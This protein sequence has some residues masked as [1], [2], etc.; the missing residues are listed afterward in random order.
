[1]RILILGGTR[2]LG[3]AIT[4]AAL[5]RGD[6]VTL[7]NRGKSSPGLYPGLE[8]VIG[9][10]AADLSA[11]DGREWDAVIDVACYDPVVA[12]LSA[13]AFADRAG[14]YVFVSTVSV[15]ASQD[16]TQA[17]LEDAPV[18][19]LREGMQFPESYGPDKA[20]CEQVVHDVYG[21]RALVGRPGL[22]V[23]PLDRTDRF[24][25]WPRRIARGGRVLAPGDPADRVQF[26]DVRDLAAWFADACHAGTG[27]V[28]NLT[29]T[30][31]PFGRML[32]LCKAAVH[33]EAELR[34]IPSER[35]V[36][37]GVDPG[38]GIPLWIAEPGCEAINDVDSSRAVAVGLACRPVIDTIRDT[39]AWDAARG[40]PAPGDE[41]LSA[42]E[43]GRLL[44]ELDG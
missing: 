18:G 17:Q 9:D 37:A 4:E 13:E 1:M 43:E 42:A 39:L 2:F 32:D 22:I 14:R 15:Y 31:L 8:T 23:G 35:L 10:R 11:L 29:G 24:A 38:M 41:G 30:P 28:Y 16:T 33:S 21:D 25:Y 34:W 27:G 7:F 3:R 19:Q 5:G 36:A 26:I 12:R 20:L 44:R 6:I 40:G